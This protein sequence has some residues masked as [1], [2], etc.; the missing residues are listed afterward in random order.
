VRIAARTRL[1]TIAVAV[2]LGT[3]AMAA[4]PAG[5]ADACSLVS[6]SAIA[7][8][9]GLS[10]AQETSSA[11]QPGNGSGGVASDCKVALW[12]GSTPTSAQQIQA[13]V[14]NGTAAQLIINT[15]QEDAG[16]P[17][18]EKYRTSGFEHEWVAAV[19]GASAALIHALH[20]SHFPTPRYGAES[21]V[22]D[23]AVKRGRGEADGIWASPE[24]F[25][26]I[27]IDVVAKGKS[28]ARDA[29]KIAKIAVPAFGL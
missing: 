26:F 12:S 29:A 14:S 17:E 27:V 20:G 1:I 25:A 9:F 2:A 15:R 24:K 16:S 18:A 28:A 23:Q 8:A 5:A 4:P 11:T 21:A 3:L 19:A 6:S 10:H 22:G 7:K 13:K